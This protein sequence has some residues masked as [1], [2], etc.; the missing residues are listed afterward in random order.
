MTVIT[1]SRQMG[2]GGDAIATRVCEA[3]GY[4]YFDKALMVEAAAEVGLC[5]AEVV[6]F[7]AEKYKVQ[8]FISRLLRSRP[9][10]VKEVLFREAQHGVVETLTARTLN[11]ADCA[12]L[13][14]YAIERA[15]DQGDT[16]IVGRGG[17]AILR[18]KPGVLHV[19]IIAPLAVRMQHIRASGMSGV[20]E[21]KQHIANADRSSAEYLKRF[22]D[23]QWDDPALYQMTLNMDQFTA[24]A[25]VQTIVTAVKVQQAVATA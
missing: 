5:E 23:V 24:D 14:R 13:V 1:I 4:R 11:E 19:R 17:Q 9:R 16:V 22:F 8:D 15:Y 20:S 2:S 7:S 21:I 18:G 12:A 10:A 3:L 25:A 6:D